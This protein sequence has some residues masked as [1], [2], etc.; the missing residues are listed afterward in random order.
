MPIGEIEEHPYLELGHTPHATRL[1]LGSFP[2]YECTN[3]ETEVK[4]V[5]RN[6]GTVRFFYGSNRNRLWLLYSAY[7]DA[8]V[9]P[10]WNGTAII[11]SLSQRNIA[12]SDTIRSCERFEFSSD[13]PALS[14]QVWNVDQ[15]R[16]L[17]N[18]GVS[19]ILC[20]S[21]GVLDTLSARIINAHD[22]G[23]LSIE[24]TATFQADFIGG[25][26]GDLDQIT[27][28]CCRCFIVNGRTIY[29]VAIPSPGSPQRRL[30][31]F[32]FT[33]GNSMEYAT[34]Y[35]QRAFEWLTE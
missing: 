33:G 1:I 25:I 17:I 28:P 8:G 11:E 23:A 26:D 9:L 5:R 34:A 32:G 12:I 7:V 15:I 30:K 6:D 3:P 35:F 2:V 24:E 29:T 10:P 13:D 16:T 31:H 21:K 27:N 19:K 4:A 22:F 14:N 20:T 18:T